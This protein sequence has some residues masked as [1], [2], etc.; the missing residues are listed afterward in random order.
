MKYRFVESMP[1]VRGCLPHGL[2]TTVPS[3]SVWHH[4]PLI[5]AALGQALTVAF[6]DAMYQIA[7]IRSINVLVC[8]LAK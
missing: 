5:F 6:T 3:I 8:A 4:P 7:I 1:F 2:T